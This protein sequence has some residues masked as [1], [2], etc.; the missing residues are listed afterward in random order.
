MCNLSRLELATKCMHAYVPN[1]HLLT[2][3]QVLGRAS[4]INSFVKNN[5]D[6]G[7]IEIELKGKKGEPNLVI[8]RNLVAKTKSSSFT[9]NGKV[10]TGKEITAR[11]AE[12]NVQVGNLWYDGVTFCHVVEVTLLCSSFLPQ[13]KVS[14]FA[15]MSSQQL[16]RE[17]QRAAGDAHLT[18]WHDTLIRSGKELKQLQEV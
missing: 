4:E 15:G 11:M 3:F 18:S 13:D 6:D 8:R 2:R 9:L 17:T 7:H 1:H 10:A 14:E 12:L 16:L 5:T